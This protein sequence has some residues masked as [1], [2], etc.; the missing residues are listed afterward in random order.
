MIQI[1]GFQ[2]LKASLDTIFILKTG[3]GLVMDEF[4]QTKQA[5][6]LTLK[7]QQVNSKSVCNSIFSKAELKKNGISF[8]QVRR[9]LPRGFTSDIACLGNDFISEVNQYTYLLL[10]SF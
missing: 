3:W 8:F 9:A 2:N 10:I 1:P 5:K 4:G 6:T 7:P